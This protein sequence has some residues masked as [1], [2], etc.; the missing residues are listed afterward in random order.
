MLPTSHAG[1]EKRSEPLASD[2]RD[3]DGTDDSKG[4][5]LG[6]TRANLADQAW[7]FAALLG[8]K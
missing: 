8:V 5:V 7:A 6:I 2:S 1:A 3:R 4:E